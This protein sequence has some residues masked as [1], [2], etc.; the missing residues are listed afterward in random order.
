MSI[1][2][3]SNPQRVLHDGKKRELGSCTGPENKK[4]MTLLFI[5]YEWDRFFESFHG[6]FSLLNANCPFC[7]LF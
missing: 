3:F 5:E 1:W 6:D 2:H 4:Y 7:F